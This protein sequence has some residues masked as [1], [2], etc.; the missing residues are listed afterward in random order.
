MPVDGLGTEALGHGGRC[1][2]LLDQA[3]KVAS[4][5]SLRVRRA[6]CSTSTTAPTLR[7]SS[8]CV[9]GAV[10]AGA[11]MAWSGGL[12]AGLTKA[13]ATRVGSAL[14]QQSSPTRLVSTW[15]KGK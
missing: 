10:G 2:D 7:D 5:C 8:N 11:G 9:A 6:P 13:Y 1:A 3:M 12:C 15:L 14:F 4:T